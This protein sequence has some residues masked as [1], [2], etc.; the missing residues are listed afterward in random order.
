MD[1]FLSTFLY[2]EFKIGK[3]TFTTMDA[4][5][6]LI[7]SLL[8]IVARL[9]LFPIKSLDFDSFLSDWLGY[10][11]KYGVWGSLRLSISDYTSPY[12][13]LMCIASRFENDFYALKAV[14]VI[15]DF[16]GAIAIGL[17]VSQLTGDSRKALL[18]Y[19]ITILCPTVI[20]NSAWWCQ[21]DMIYSSFIIFALVSLFKDKGALCCF[22]LGLAF[23]FKLQ[24]V[25][26][27]PLILILLVKGRTIKIWHLF[28]IP[29]AY[30]VMHIPAL[31]AGRPIVQVMKIYL[32]QSQSYGEWTLNI[33]FWMEHSITVIQLKLV[34]WGYAS[35]SVQSALPYGGCVKKSS[36]STAKL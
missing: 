18:G 4:L 22:F 34:I 10:I 20:I 12:M 28:L 26:I 27:F 13:Y 19:F 9:S 30:L 11:H 32:N 33:C 3:A 1:R 23:S 7:V 25:F 8:A 5:T 6:V 31:I 2:K 14:S 21:C 29:L 17:L 36:V 35:L 24:T 15:F 16:I